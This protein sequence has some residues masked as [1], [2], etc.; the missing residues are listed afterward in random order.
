MEVLRGGVNSL[1]LGSLGLLGE[2]RGCAER[3]MCGECRVPCDMGRG[4]CDCCVD[5]FV[6]LPFRK[7][8]KHKTSALIQE[9]TI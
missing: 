5:C 6:A 4:L 3:G 9:D 1:L 2:L 7:E 8:S